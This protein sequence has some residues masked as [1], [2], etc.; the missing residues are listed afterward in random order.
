MDQ[1]TV[2]ST[3]APTVGNV[4]GFSFGGLFGGVNP[5]LAEANRQTEALTKEDIQFRYQGRGMDFW[6]TKWK[7][8]DPEKAAKL[9]TE[10]EDSLQVKVGRN[11]WLPLNGVTGL[12]TLYH[13][14]FEPEKLDQPEL[15]QDLKQ[16][17]S[18]LG[19]GGV[20]GA[21]RNLTH[22][23]SVETRHG[24]V[25]SAAE[26]AFLAS[27]TQGEKG[28]FLLDLKAEGFALKQKPLD[29]FRQ[30]LAG[31]PVEIA[32]QGVVLDAVKPNEDLK[33][34]VLRLQ[35]R[36]QKF[37]ALLARLPKTATQ[38]WSLLNPDSE[39]DSQLQALAELRARGCKEPGPYIEQLVK[40]E[41][42][43]ETLKNYD[44]AQEA[45]PGKA[46]ELLG[47]L[48]QL[49]SEKTGFFTALAQG[50]PEQ[51]NDA[52]KAVEQQQALSPE[53]VAPLL[54]LSKAPADLAAKARAF[55]STQ[56]PAETL[57][58]LA[59]HS[60]LQ[61]WTQG[62]QWTEVRAGVFSEAIGNYPDSANQSLSRAVDLSHHRHAELSFK[63]DSEYEDGYDFLHVEVRPQGQNEWVELQKI[64]GRQNGEF[65]FP[66]S[67]Y[68]GQRVDIRFRFQS[69]TGTNRRASELSALKVEASPR[70]GGSKED[71][72]SRTYSNAGLLSELLDAA[73]SD[74]KTRLERLQSL[75]EEGA[76]TLVSRLTLN[77][78]QVSGPALQLE[79]A[80]GPVVAER[81]LQQSGTV[82]EKIG[83]FKAAARLSGQGLD[84]AMALYGQLDRVDGQALG[85]LVGQ[86][87]ARPFRL[88]NKWGPADLS[89]TVWAT[90]PHDT[91][92]HNR[93]DS[94]SFGPIDLTEVEKARLVFSSR[95][96]LEENYDRVHLEVSNDGRDW[97]ALKD[98]TGNA[99]WSEESVTLNGFEG[100]PLWA[101]FRLTSDTGTDREGFFLKDLRLEG[102]KNY[103][104]GQKPEAIFDTRAAQREE[105]LKTI[106]EM[107]LER[108]EQIAALNSFAQAVGDVGA[109]LRVWPVVSEQGFKEPALLAPLLGKM[110]LEPARQLLPAV[111]EGPREQLAERV[112]RAGKAW[113]LSQK[114]LR[115]TDQQPD[116]KTLVRLTRGIFSSG[117][118]P[119]EP[120]FE[121]L[122]EELSAW[123]PEGDWRRQEGAWR[124]SPM[125][126]PYANSANQSLVSRPIELQGAVNPK[127]TF[128]AHHELE[129]NYDHVHLEVSSDGK[130]WNPLQSYTGNSGWQNQEF[131][132]A[133][134]AGE[135]VQI[136]FR[137]ATDTGTAHDG[138]AVRGVKV[139]EGSRILF[140]DLGQDR[141]AEV[142]ALATLFENDRD[143]L[144]ER[145]SVVGELSEELANIHSGLALYQA[146]LPVMNQPAYQQTR[147]F[148]VLAT[149]RLGVE[150]ALEV[151][152][153]LR[154][155]KAPVDQAVA[156]LVARE[157]QKVSGTQTT[158]PPMDP[159]L[160]RAMLKL[161]DTAPIAGWRSQGW[162]RV[163]KGW[164][165]SPYRNY[166]SSENRSLVSPAFTSQGGEL[167]VSFKADYD[168]EENYDQ[169]HLEWSS[170]GNNWQEVKSF[171]GQANGSESAVVAAPPGRVQLRFRLTSDTGTER[172]G[173]SFTDLRVSGDEG[174]LYRDDNG[175]GAA[176]AIASMNLNFQ[177]GVL[178]R[179]TQLEDVQPG[180][181]FEI[182]RRLQ[183]AGVPD[184]AG[185]LE[186]LTADL[187]V[188]ESIEVAWQAYLDSRHVSD[189]RI[190]EEEVIVG[191]FAIEVK[192]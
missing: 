81:L 146:L 23:G 101:R 19:D 162:A 71:L 155:G 121:G 179:L 107:A 34:A 21:Y 176:R 16:A 28:H 33:D 111:M 141:R 171:T 74:L 135:Q 132:L 183:E 119:Q 87:D 120:V 129:N 22:N 1:V 5:V 165:D 99:G 57:T 4:L 61:G 110:G 44:R 170:A 109:A 11:A 133:D 127:L 52:F 86:A 102:R 94:L 180:A 56:L 55:S 148:M 145:L 93:N 39:L 46:V 68:D 2:S 147:D 182:L 173:F 112:E 134:Y 104:P 29:A 153:E 142:E 76:S 192:D 139:K 9:A 95:F 106:Q 163:E 63:L 154:E 89:E 190:E 38:D 20:L 188:S 108:P 18:V 114:L 97:T 49:P 144:M 50:F 166:G 32:H 31:K 70:Y 53:L 66:L 187:L 30:G 6:K 83:R 151:S 117:V 96:Q 123:R 191:D 189:I 69:D 118:N 48:E 26:A 113:T 41:N 184:L 51:L 164:D 131:S 77:G 10:K 78:S 27:W 169:V 152:K 8:A 3:H 90:N 122:I 103:Q 67:R 185:A 45:L 157:I 137:E 181:G 82:E 35:D 25:A 124:D 12:T 150:S 17:Q 161:L 54:K 40:S 60:A 98:F 177:A 75:N 7:P 159:S 47:Y 167:N 15:A 126:L 64:G 174:V 84:S 85:Q 125:G 73:P 14:T 58:E 59:G 138:F 130:T 156:D 116:L 43:E 160:G 24:Q 62:G 100:G 149:Q 136:R 128:E 175:A 168:L 79:E 80:L 178:T 105:N 158:L 92:G 115:A 88:E 91:Y 72:L 37:E 13:L 143:T 140:T 186:R 65:R 36:R 42:S 172:K